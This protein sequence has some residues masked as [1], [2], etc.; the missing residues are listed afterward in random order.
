MN[1]TIASEA[2]VQAVL[3]LHVR[4]DKPVRSLD[5]AC[6]RHMRPGLPDFPAV[7]A[8]PDCRTSEYYVCSHCQCPRDA[9]PCATYRAVSDALSGCAPGRT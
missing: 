7:M 4:Q 9:W 8:C 1:A 5:W 6:A 3:K 2:A